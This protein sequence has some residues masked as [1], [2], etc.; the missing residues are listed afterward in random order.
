M[1]TMNSPLMQPAAPVPEFPPNPP[2]ETWITPR[3][4]LTGPADPAP[5]ILEQETWHLVPD[6]E[7][8][9]PIPD[10]STW[11]ITWFVPP[12]PE[13]VVEEE[14]EPEPVVE[15]EKPPRTPYG[16]G[17]EATSVR[18]EL[19]GFKYVKCPIYY[20]LLALFGP[21]MLKSEATLVLHEIKDFLKGHG[22]DLPVV[23]RNTRRMLSLLVKYMWDNRRYYAPLL[24]CVRLREPNGQFLTVRADA[25]PR[26]VRRDLRVE[27][28]VPPAWK[29]SD[30]FG[31]VQPAPAPAPAPPAP[32]RPAPARPVR[33]QRVRT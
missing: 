14:E 30:W 15:K 16:T 2:Q 25:V 32:A 13:P 17:I 26:G 5:D 29:P 19:N 18:A 7:F 21:N 4:G 23:T 22:I 8:V 24:R 28:A 12:I 11:Q 3:L 31:N 10:L 1:L 6:P 27:V 20:Q 33:R 9:E